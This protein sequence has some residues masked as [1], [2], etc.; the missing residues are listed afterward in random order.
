[1]EVLGSPVPL[2]AP[3]QLCVAHSSLLRDTERPNQTQ[4]TAYK[5]EYLLPPLQAERLPQAG[6]QTPDSDLDHG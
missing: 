4:R 3:I 1:M 6:A 2:L 5:G